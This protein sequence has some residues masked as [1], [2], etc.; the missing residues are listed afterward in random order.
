M[1]GSSTKPSRNSGRSWRSRP[2]NDSEQYDATTYNLMGRALA[3]KGEMAEALE[4]L[5]KATQLHPGFGPHLYDYAL[6]LVQVNRFDDAQ[7][8]VEA[9]LR[10]DADLAEAHELRGELLARKAAIGRGGSRVSAGAGIA[11]RL[12]PRAFGSGNGSGRAGRHAG[13]RATSSRGCQRQ[14]WGDCPGGY[15]GPSAARA[16]VVRA[17]PKVEFQDEILLPRSSRGPRSDS[18]RGRHPGVLPA[19]IRRFRYRGPWPPSTRR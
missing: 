1:R 14:R 15:P 2:A 3:G 9:A 6:A 10:A 11:A 4:D 5:E 19:H 18:L 12:Q 16:T 13:R 8:S 17:T 7:E